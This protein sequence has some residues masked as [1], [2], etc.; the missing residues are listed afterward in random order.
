M[1]IIINKRISIQR[2]GAHRF[3]LGDTQGGIIRLLL[4]CVCV[5]GIIGEIFAKLG[6]FALTG[7]L[8]LAGALLVVYGIMVAVRP[9]ERATSIPLPAL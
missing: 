9:R 5:G 2:F 4:S 7:I 8:L 1:L 3:Y 6:G